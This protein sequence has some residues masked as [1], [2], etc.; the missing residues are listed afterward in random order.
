MSGLLDPAAAGAYSAQDMRRRIALAMLMKKHTAPKTFG[1]GL[2]SIGDS[3]SDAYT[4]NALARRTQEES[5]AENK[6]I[7]S[8]DPSQKLAEANILADD[9]TAAPARTAALPTS[10]SGNIVAAAAPPPPTIMPPRQISPMAQQ[11]ALMPTEPPQAFFPSTPQTASSAPPSQLALNPPPPPNA[12]VLRNP[13]PAMADTAAVYDRMPPQPPP[14]GPG[15]DAGGAM[16]P[17]QS[18]QLASLMR[19]PQAPPP[20]PFAATAAL[21]TPGTA[22]DAPANPLVRNGV[23]SALMAQQGAPTPPPP[24]PQVAQATPPSVFPPVP[25][26]VQPVLPGGGFP[27]VQP[28]VQPPPPPPQVQPAPQ[29]P[30]AGIRPIPDEY[31][32]Q[33]RPRPEPPA[34][35]TMGPIEQ[36]MIRDYINADVSPRVKAAAQLRID[37]ERNQLNS[38]YEN[39]LKNYTADEKDWQEMRKQER[40]YKMKLPYQRAQTEGQYATTAKTSAEIPKT[41][42]E[43]DT[44]VLTNKFYQRT[45]R[46]RE[47]FLKELTSDKEVVS[48]VAGQL[49]QTKVMDEAIRNGSLAGM[50]ADFKLNL[51]RVGAA[52]GSQDAAKVAAATEQYQMAAKSLI[53]YGTMLVNGKDPRVTDSDVKQAQGI[54]GDINLQRASQQ[55]ILNV[56]REDMYGKVAEYEDKRETYLRDDPQ[57]RMFKVPTPETAPPAVTKTLLDHQD[58]ERIRQ[59]YDADY[60]PGAAALEIARAKRREKRARAATAEDD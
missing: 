26:N 11:A 40:D 30:N 34:K 16:N 33:D 50:G 25:A 5:E 13:L 15:S 1:E 60:G 17:A 32:P 20:S 49:R 59:R 12:N 9:E 51:N 42:A 27:Q 52:I 22:S 23:T 38:V 55:K 10:A 39:K 43:A 14:P 36:R 35:P 28:S 48:K 46:D 21:Q 41:Q 54:T 18:G 2:Y 44:A 53:S 7:K 6:T 37:A 3:L 56:M 19:P 31:V 24:N 57:H 29:P 4:A 47:P 58:N 45:G 8:M